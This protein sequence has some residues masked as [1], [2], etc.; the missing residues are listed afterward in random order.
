M[1]A[2]GLIEEVL[3]VGHKVEWTGLLDLQGFLL[4]LEEEVEELFLDWVPVFL[5]KIVYI[6]LV[7]DL[8]NMFKVFSPPTTVVVGHQPSRVPEGS[9][10]LASPLRLGSLWRWGRRWWW[11]APP[12]R[13][14]TGGQTTL[15]TLS[16][17]TRHPW[18]TSWVT[19]GVAAMSP[20]SH[21]RPSA[22]LHC[23]THGGAFIC[24]GVSSDSPPRSWYQPLWRLHCLLVGRG[25]PLQAWLSD[26]HRLGHARHHHGWRWHLLGQSAW[27]GRSHNPLRRTP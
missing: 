23:A 2:S 19:N 3:D 6:K 5:R 16:L 13:C 8:Q 1:E 14:R 15:L 11:E 17:C 9:P 26:R 12:T 24:G 18:C 22:V 21:C 25:S 20:P 27:A 7:V 4:V 10:F